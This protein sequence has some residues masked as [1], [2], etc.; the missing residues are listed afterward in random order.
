MRSSE[1][2][3][4]TVARAI[5][6]I[7]ATAS[8][9]TSTRTLVT[10]RAGPLGWLMRELEVTPRQRTALEDA[11]GDFKGELRGVKEALFGGRH[12]LAE[13]MRKDDLDVELLGST[14]A[15]GDETL[16]RARHAL[17]N[18]TA[19]VHQVLDSEQRE[20]LA[21]LLERRR[22]SRFNWAW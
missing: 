15:G 7:T 3:A 20:R 12:D 8:V 17:A 10:G 2:H 4:P 18:L 16:D 6:A 5:T 22:G 1:K 14:L 19:E 11:F 21:S 9:T 13:A